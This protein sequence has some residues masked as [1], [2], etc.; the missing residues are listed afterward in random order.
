MENE[1]C[2]VIENELCRLTVGGDCIVKS[3]V[4]R[5]TGEECLRQGEEISLFSVTQ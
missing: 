1:N 5:E 2:I 3:L 4:V